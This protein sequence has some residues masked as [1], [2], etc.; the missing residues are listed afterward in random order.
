[1]NVICIMLDSLRTDHAGAYA[2]AAA[3]AR[4]PNMDRFAAESTR[5][6]IG[7]PVV[8]PAS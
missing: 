2:G 1:M 3:R 6:A 5:A 7:S 8:K 4:T